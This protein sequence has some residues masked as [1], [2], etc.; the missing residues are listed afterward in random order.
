MWINAWLASPKS[1]F[2]NFRR[3]GFDFEF[4]LLSVVVGGGTKFI[5]PHPAVPAVLT[6]TTT[7][8][9]NTTS[10]MSHSSAAMDDCFVAM[11]DCAASM[12]DCF[13]AM[14]DCAASMDDCFAAHRIRDTERG[15]P[16]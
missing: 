3:S 13:A 7:T 12:D 1:N 8:N 15:T 6:A 10:T 11:D 4:Y 5:H 16:N 14:G 2:H 9:T